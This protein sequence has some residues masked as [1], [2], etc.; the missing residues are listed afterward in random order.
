MTAVRAPATFRRLAGD[1]ECL[2]VLRQQLGC[3][4]ADVVEPAGELA[5]EPGGERR[6]PVV[7]PAGEGLA[8][9]P[10]LVAQP[11]A[12]ALELD[13]PGGRHRVDRLAERAQPADV[14]QHPGGEPAE[15]Q[16][17]RLAPRLELRSHLDQ[18]TD[19]RQVAPG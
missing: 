11:G 4:D 2:G 17:E 13:A 1:R 19:E 9:Q 6:R 5:L 14:D 3:L 7:E 15:R 8:V 16:V 10:D 18:L 12:H